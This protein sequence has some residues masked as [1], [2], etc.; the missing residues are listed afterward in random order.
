MTKEKESKDLEVKQEGALALR[1]SG[2]DSLPA[3]FDGVEESD[4]KMPRLSI[5]QG[6]S[7]ICIEGKGK[8][9][10][11]ANS[12]T[13]EVYGES[14]EFIPLFMFKTRAQ[15]ETGKGLVMYSR[16]NIKVTMALNEFSEYIDKPVEE[17]PGAEWDGDQPPTFGVVYNFPIM[18]VGNLF[19]FPISLSL[20]KTATKAAK[21]LVSM[22][23][24]SGE[25]M[26]ARVYS[27]K[28]KIEKSDQGTY[29]V[30]VIEFKRRCTDEEYATAKIVFDK[31]YRLKSK[32]DVE[33][34]ATEE[35]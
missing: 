28:S 25:D 3:G 22:A 8:M 4:I 33:L 12:L 18:L 14:V 20:M 30:P 13:K 31:I 32:I 24:Y 16:D 10:E 34:E 2:I 9:G 21:E 26:F 15:F 5:L 19:Q 29:A 35:K 1:R 17:V 23:R 11:L 27:I 6:L 7:E